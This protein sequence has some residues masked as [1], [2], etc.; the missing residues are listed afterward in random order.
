[1]SKRTVASTNYH[2]DAALSLERLLSVCSLDD[3]LRY[4]AA[5]AELDAS[6]AVSAVADDAPY[7]FELPTK[8]PAPL[9]TTPHLG[10]ESSTDSESEDPLR[11]AA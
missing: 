10:R 9:R 11:G 7:G 2:L 6:A 4:A 8:G 1:M 5:R 3:V